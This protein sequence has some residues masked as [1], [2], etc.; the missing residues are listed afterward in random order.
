LTT[1]GLLVQHHLINP[2]VCESRN[3]QIV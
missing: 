2:S 3:Y 1:L